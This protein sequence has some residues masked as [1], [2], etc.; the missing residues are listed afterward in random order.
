MVFEAHA[1]LQD[2]SA[3]ETSAKKALIEPQEAADLEI[4][5]SLLKDQ[6]W[7]NKMGQDMVKE[8]VELSQK[9]H[10]QK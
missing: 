9:H 6:R 3:S 7:S 8:V 5:E 2:G 10:G 1:K 4:L